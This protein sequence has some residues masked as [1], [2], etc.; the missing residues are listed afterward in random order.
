MQRGA[1]GGVVG[2][3]GRTHSRSITKLILLTC[4]NLPQNSPH[5]LPTS[6]LGQIRNNKDSLR[7]RKWTDTLPN[8]QNEVFSQLIIDFVA[9]FDGH[10]SVDCLASEFVIDTYDGG[11]CDGAVFYECGFDFGG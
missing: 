1:L 6:C 7:S 5:N 11:F 9:V 4:Q 8:L 2:K 10:E 3:R